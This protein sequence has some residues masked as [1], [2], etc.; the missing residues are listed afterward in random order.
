MGSDM[1]RLEEISESAEIRKYVKKIYIADDAEKDENGRGNRTCFWPRVDEYYELD[2]CTIPMIRTS[3]IGLNRLKFILAEGKLC[4]RAIVI[5][6]FSVDGDV[7]VMAPINAFAED[8]C[9]GSGLAVS[10]VRIQRHDN[11][12]IARVYLECSTQHQGQNIGY[13]MLSHAELSLEYGSTRYWLNNVFFHSPSLS[14]LT[15][16]SNL[17][18][19]TELDQIL[20]TNMIVSHLKCLTLIHAEWSAKSILKVLEKSRHS[21]TSL[22]LSYITL[23]IEPCWIDLLN[24]IGDDF[25]Q[26][27]SFEINRISESSEAIFNRIEFQIRDKSELAEEFRAGLDLFVEG[28]GDT[29]K[30]RHWCHRGQNTGALL[31]AMALKA[32]YS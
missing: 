10:S 16:V 11:E 9:E 25:T 24:K 6:D 18:T 17:C 14:D 22:H 2:D 4:P 29:S 27:S 30:V 19:C 1:K 28:E 13:K 7:I 31:K 26:L 5:R 20:S 15:C 21:L 12:R 8:L 23:S 3:D 32:V